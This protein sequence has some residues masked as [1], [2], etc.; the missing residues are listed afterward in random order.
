S[1][2]FSQP[3]NA[4]GISGN[5]IYIYS[6]SNGVLRS[7]D[8][9]NVWSELDSGLHY[10]V[11]SLAVVGNDIFAGTYGGVYI[12]RNNGTVWDSVNTGLPGFPVLKLAVD[13]NALYAGTDSGGV[14]RTSD[15]GAHWTAIN[16]GLTNSVVRAIYAHNGN[17]FAGTNEGVFFSSDG[18]GDWQAENSG[19]GDTLILSLNSD[20]KYIYAGTA[21]AGVYRRPLSDFG[22]NAVNDSLPV[23]P[24]QFS[25]LQN[26]PNPFDA[27]TTISYLLPEASHVMLKVYNAIGEEVATLVNE[28]NTAGEHSATFSA[29]DL[30]NGMYFYK[31]TAGKY[32]QTGKMA[33]VK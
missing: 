16:N 8:C 26:Y 29:H 12:I 1:Q 9:G 22:I 32:A 17:L 2:I 10:N 28:E 6:Q 18:G 15:E 27:A 3:I 23:L 4:M 33:V 25:L 24:A 5:D 14:Y 30:Q 7:S 13:G 11:F 20:G 31:L 21:D 19:M